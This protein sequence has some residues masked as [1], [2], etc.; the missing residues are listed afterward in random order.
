[1]NVFLFELRRSWR[2]ILAACI[3]QGIV[4]AVF[5]GG[6]YP[7]YHDSQ[8]DVEK[9]L[10]GFPPQFAAAFGITDNMFSFGG[11]FSFTYTYFALIAAIFG[12]L[13]GLRIIG[14]EKIDRCMDFLAS[15]P[16]SRLGVFWAKAA[17]ILVGI[18]AMNVVFLGVALWMRAALNVDNPAPGRLSLMVAAVA[19][20]QL[21]FAALGALIAVLA[22]HLRS[23]TG[24]GVGLGILGFIL[25]ALPALTDDD[26]FKAISPFN[27]FDVA[28]MNAHGTYST[29]YVAVAAGVF[30]VATVVACAVYVRSDVKA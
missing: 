29:G 6:M 21:I 7:M 16:S 28:S 4:A 5:L 17:V 30:A 2:S 26:K 8:K 9:V 11:F 1:M 24:I 10:A 3:T 20:A 15:K 22:P 27:Y 18:V 25:S 12:A 13:W 14:R 19:G 23:V